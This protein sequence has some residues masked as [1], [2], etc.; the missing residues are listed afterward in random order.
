MATVT[1]RANTYRP[2]KISEKR[3]SLAKRFLNAY[4]EHQVSI[5]CGLMALNGSTN[6]YPLYKTLTKST[7]NSFLSPENFI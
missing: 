6:V 5:I 3:M 4:K 1:L 7:I 2:V